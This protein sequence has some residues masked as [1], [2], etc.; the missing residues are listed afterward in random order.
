MTAPYLL[1]P[2]YEFPNVNLALREPDG[3]LAVGGDLS[4]ERL[5]LAYTLGIFPWYSQ[6]QPILWW[7]PDPR[8]TLKPTEVKVSRSLAKTIRSQK[9][10]ITF[11]QNFNRVIKSCSESRLEKGQLQ[12]D[13]WILDDMIDAYINLHQAGYAHSVECWQGDQLVGGLYGVAIG[14]VFFGESMFSR[15]S[16]ASKVAFVYLCTQLE[17][18]G[19]QLIDCQVYTAHL[20]SLG[21]TLISRD[22]FS[23]DLKRYTSDQ[24]YGLWTADKNLH[25]IVI[26]NLKSKT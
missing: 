10:H 5:K 21:A 4:L 14:K 8:M 25:D 15:E 24:Q 20:E 11:D 1:S 16:N 12:N 19:Y 23:E 7:S 26:N 6:G 22:Q 3:L 17:Q 13:T 2:R 9:F 18:W